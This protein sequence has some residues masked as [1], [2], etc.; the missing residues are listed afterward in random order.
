M[1]YAS[2]YTFK[3]LRPKR[4]EFGFGDVTVI[5]HAIE[6]VLVADRHL[7]GQWLDLRFG[8]GPFPR[9]GD[10]VGSFLNHSRIRRRHLR[11][12]LRPVRPRCTH[13]RRC[14][15]RWD[16][17]PYTSGVPPVLPHSIRRGI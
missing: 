9:R 16:R 8:F 6:R 4:V 10:H 13:D 14:H 3:S 5:Q 11:N 17:S 1:S 12:S 15:Q 7:R 2:L